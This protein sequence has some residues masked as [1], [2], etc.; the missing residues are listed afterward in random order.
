MFA[1]RGA[2]RVAA[3]SLSVIMMSR[4][5]RPRAI[6]LPRLRAM[7]VEW[8]ES[9][10]TSLAVTAPRCGPESRCWGALVSWFRRR[11]VCCIRLV[12]GVMDPIEGCPCCCPA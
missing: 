1:G 12:G 5:P 2:A 8:F 6:E 11:G 9:V 4:M 10:C 7:V 3:I